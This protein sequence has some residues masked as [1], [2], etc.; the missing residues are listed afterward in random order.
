MGKS[1]KKYF[2]N[3]KRIKKNLKDNHPQKG[4]INWWEANFCN[5]N[6]KSERQLAKKEIINWDIE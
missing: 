3:V 5:G 2:G 4:F 6:K 1:N